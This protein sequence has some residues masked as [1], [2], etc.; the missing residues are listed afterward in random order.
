MKRLIVIGINYISLK[1]Q[2]LINSQNCSIEAFVSDNPNNIGKHIN[3]IPVIPLS[4]LNK[5]NY[6]YIILVN[7]MMLESNDNKI[8]NLNEFIRYFYDFEIY[9]SF[10]QY[11]EKKKNLHA[12][13]TG[14][15]FAEVGINA[16]EFPFS[17]VNFAN[18]SQDLYFDYNI[19]K[20]IFS[21]KNYCKNIEY[22]FI[23]LSYYSFNYDLSK[24]SLK[25]RVWFY[26]PFLKTLHNY[27]DTNNI[28][29]KLTLFESIEREVLTNNFKSTLFQL[30][31]TIN[32]ANWDKFVSGVFSASKK[33]E[34]IRLALKDSKKNFPLTVQENISI[35]NEY[36]KLLKVNNVTPI[37]VICPTTN[38]Y[39]DNISSNIKKAFNQILSYFKDTE[40]V[41]II[42]YFESNFFD[43]IDFYDATHLNKH[44]SKKFTNLL[45]EEIS[46]IQ[47]LV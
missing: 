20:Y 30:L 23:G 27:T 39:Y 15:S 4:D 46:K 13:I 22:C 44:G 37:I 36:I 24:S 19:A 42:D 11:E 1:I 26:Y 7:D 8:L 9:R 2:L 16:N 31:A 18:S 28:L 21:N 12:F 29:N 43:Y 6:D 25:E 40:Q 3:S 47:S 33:D 38:Y 34:G 10:F 41:T 17:T 32:E 35:L 45:I 5:F 14:L